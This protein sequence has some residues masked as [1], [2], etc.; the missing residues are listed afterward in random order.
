MV[1]KKLVL[2]SKEG[3]RI[4]FTESDAVVVDGNGETRNLSYGFVDG[5]LLPK[6][7][8]ITPE[9]GG[10][11]LHI[12]ALWYRVMDVRGNMLVL[13]N[14]TTHANEVYTKL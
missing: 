12:D 7:A 11:Y 5:A 3:Q 6:E 2:L 4:K 13:L 1:K 9:P 8:K 14:E 10:V